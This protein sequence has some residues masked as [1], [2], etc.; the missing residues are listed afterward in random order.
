[1]KNALDEDLEINADLFR[2]T[3]AAIK[4]EKK[5]FEMEWFC[6]PITSWTPLEEV[7]DAKENG[8]Q[9]FTTAC[10]AGWGLLLGRKK[11]LVYL[12]GPRKGQQRYDDFEAAAR[13]EFGLTFYQA[14]TLFYMHRWP[15][16]YINLAAQKG[17]AVAACRLITDFLKVRGDLSKLVVS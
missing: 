7:Q 17:E 1:M 13:E 11:S 15:N 6:K 3:R 16:A 12:R 2:E 10:M 4:K 9:C 14:K 5:A 8:H